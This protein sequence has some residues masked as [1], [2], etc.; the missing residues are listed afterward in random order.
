M[1]FNWRLSLS[2]PMLL[3]AQLCAGEPEDLETI[4][5]AFDDQLYL[6]VLDRGD[7]FLESS[8]YDQ[9]G[10]SAQKVRFYMIAGAVR[11]G[12]HEEALK[13]IAQ[14]ETMFPQSQETVKVQVYKAQALY[15]GYVRNGR[16]LPEAYGALRPAQIIAQVID[17]IK[18][19][20]E[21]QSLRAQALYIQGLDLFS[22]GSREGYQLA[23]NTL[24][25]LYQQH[26]AFEHR[27]EGIFFLAQSYYFLDSFDIALT[28]FRRL[29]ENHRKSGRFPEYE[30]WR[31]LCHFELNQLSEA[32]QAFQDAWNHQP[33][34]RTQVDLAYNMGWMY[35][36][37]GDR[38]QAKAWFRRM[39]A[40]NADGYSER[41]HDSVR[42]K[43]ASLLLLEEKHREGLVEIQPVLKSPVLA[44]KASLLAAQFH[45][46]LG[47]WEPAL[48]LL[49]TSGSSGDDMVRTESEKMRAQIHY[50][51]GEYPKAL[52]ILREL[53]RSQVP[54]DYR[55]NI[56]LQMAEAHFANGDFYDSQHIYMDLLAE[57]IP[58]LS[59][60][61]FYK[62]AMCAKMTNPLI[63]NLY[64][65]EKLGPLSHNE[66]K[67]SK[68]LDGL[69][70]GLELTLGK[71]WEKATSRRD[72]L[73]RERMLEILTAVCKQT[74]AEL[75]A[76]A[77]KDFAEA[78]PDSLLTPEILSTKMYRY[79]VEELTSLYQRQELPN[80]RDAI[81]VFAELARPYPELQAVSIHQYLDRVIELKADSPFLA[82]AYNEKASMNLQQ[83]LFTDASNNL[84]M[85]VR[86][87]ANDADRAQ[88]LFR[89]VTTE[90]RMAGDVNPDID[91]KARASRLSKVLA[92]L[93]ALEAIDR[94]DYKMKSISYRYNCYWMLRDY[95]KAEQ[96][97]LNVLSSSNDFDNLNKTED[98]LVRFYLEL[99]QPLKAAQQ[100]LRFS[101]RVLGKQP[102][103]AQQLTYE[104]AEIYRSHSDAQFNKQGDELLLELSGQIPTTRWTFMASLKAINILHAMG[105]T[106]RAS[107]LA[108]EFGHPSDL[109]E[110]LLQEKEMALAIHELTLGRRDEGLSRLEK[111]VEQAPIAS[112]LRA[113]ALLEI[114]RL[115]R[116]TEPRRAADLYYDFYTLYPQHPERQDA[117]VWCCRLNVQSYKRELDGEQRRIE[118]ERLIS[119][120][121]SND[122]RER[123]IEILQQP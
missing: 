81:T 32:Q 20:G 97:L 5:Q 80:H 112:R 4:R 56:L 17:F 8:A 98:Q 24:L 120:I 114:A 45:V 64:E 108:G 53:I 59:V 62:L 92:H 7:R 23:L 121:D 40:M 52:D 72:E 3:L 71:L 14:F 79:L 42:Y 6:F 11:R 93:D 67:L 86:H 10:L 39:L 111:L 91:P 51:R 35:A 106:E 101:A 50:E 68:T 30:F 33:D 34:P 18:N 77:K 73:T 44:D 26:K 122:D 22:T 103:L 69:V 37:Q 115:V 87:A 107:Q 58:G 75:E 78:N 15:E 83:G 95:G 66:I 76:R 27:D 49:E 113:S 63:E 99:D 109:D 2:I 89:L 116:E 94:G 74:T 90:F 46:H 119:K 43:L 60:G 9:Q 84:A 70:D 16:A 25:D 55:M 29:A 48:D 31:G 57:K 117:L 110:V 1:K 123:L 82:L 13:S 41:Y 118:L 85:A 54:L 21:G 61:L 47:E 102:E 88:Y 12:A 36:Y 28:F 19:K 38:T 105:K 96:V 65:R 100:K 104:A